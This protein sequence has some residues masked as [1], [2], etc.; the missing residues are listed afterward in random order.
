M[1]YSIKLNPSNLKPHLDIESDIQRTKD[2][3]MT[4]VVKINREL[5]IDYVIYENDTSTPELTLTP[6]N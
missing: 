5:I 6:V 4:I 2:G 1:K 3:S